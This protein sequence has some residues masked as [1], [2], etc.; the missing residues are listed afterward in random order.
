MQQDGQEIEGERERMLCS[1]SISLSNFKFS[2]GQ[3]ISLVFV[4]IHHNCFISSIQPVL[5]TSDS[6]S[7]WDADHIRRRDRLLPETRYLLYCY[8]NAAS[9]TTASA[10]KSFQ[11]H[12]QHYCYYHN[13]LQCLCSSSIY[14]LVS[15]FS[16]FY[17]TTTTSLEGT[18]IDFEIVRIFNI[19]GYGNH[20]CA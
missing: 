2:H 8:F 19:I 14:C 9:A 5:D 18:A 13:W 15:L 11:N 4:V 7:E 17:S 16:L 3:W 12:H 20:H 10:A 1:L 6:M